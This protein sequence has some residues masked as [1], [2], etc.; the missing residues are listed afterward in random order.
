MTYSGREG[1]GG[2]SLIERTSWKRFLVASVQV[3]EY[4]IFVKQKT[5]C[6]LFG[7]KNACTKCVLS[8]KD[9]PSVYL[10]RHWRQYTV[11][12]LCFPPPPFMHTVH[13]SNQKLDREE[14]C[15][16]LMLKFGDDYKIM[17][18]VIAMCYFHRIYWSTLTGTNMATVACTG[19]MPPWLIFLITSTRSRSDM[20]TTR[21]SR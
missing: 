17:Y 6:S 20:I 4:R 7:T 9:P 18:T 13:V 1:R 5:C 2:W 14:A 16:W 8:I 11:N 19:P 12:E 3:L 15:H 10:G 21:K